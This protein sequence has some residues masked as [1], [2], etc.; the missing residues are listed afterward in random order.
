MTKTVEVGYDKKMTF[1]DKVKRGEK[2][3]NTNISVTSFMNSPLLNSDDVKSISNF[4]I[5]KNICNNINASN[6]GKFST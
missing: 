6:I 1:D 2:F 3:W 4:L 5:A